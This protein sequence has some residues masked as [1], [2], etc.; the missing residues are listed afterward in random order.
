MKKIDRYKLIGV[1]LIVFATIIIGY[2]LIQIESSKKELANT[3]D[4]WENNNHLNFSENPDNESIKKAIQYPP[5]NPGDTLG[6][7][8]F[9][10]TDLPVLTGIEESLLDKGI[11][12]YGPT[13]LPGTEGNSILLG[14]RDSTFKNLKLLEIGHR[15]T[16]ET[17][18]NKLEFEVFDIKILM[19][20]D[21]SVFGSYGFPTVSMETCYPFNYFGSAPKRYIVVGKLINT[22]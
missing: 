6:K 2:A 15:F 11:L 21:I 1:L 3:L 17:T 14:H 16:I 13:P 7:L 12:H 20:N 9:L 19:P 8:M 18:Y 5:L 10:D 22:Q 4:A